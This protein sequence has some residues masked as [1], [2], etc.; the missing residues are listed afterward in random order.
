M[1]LCVR[2]RQV[3]SFYPNTF[4]KFPCHLNLE[5]RILYKKSTRIFLNKQLLNNKVDI[6]AF[7][8]EATDELQIEVK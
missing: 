7:D 5:L 1:L 4:Q 6:E 8:F 3:K 2:G